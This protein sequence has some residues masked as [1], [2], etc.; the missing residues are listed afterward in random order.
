[1][2]SLV[3]PCGEYESGYAY[4]AGTS[5]ATPLVSGLAT[6]VIEEYGPWPNPERVVQEMRDNAR[7]ADPSL[8][9][10]IIHVSDTFSGNPPP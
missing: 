8:A 3:L 9:N 7:L 2:I 10:G 4:W 1:V 5:F 6:L